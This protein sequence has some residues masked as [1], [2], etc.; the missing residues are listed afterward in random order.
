VLDDARKLVVLALA[1]ELVGDPMAL[2]AYA[3]LFGEDDD[4]TLVMYAPDAGEPFV[5]AR[6]MHALEQAGVPA[7]SGPDMLVLA[8]PG[9]ADAERALAERV[10]AVYT[11]RPLAGPLGA[12]PRYAMGDVAALRAL[13]GP[14]PAR[15]TGDGPVV[16]VVMCVWQRIGFLPATIAQLERQVGVR[17][18]LHLWVN[19]PEAA[20]HARRIAAAAAIPVQVTLSPQNI[21]G[22]GRFHAARELAG[23]HPYVVFIDDDQV[24]ADDA[25]R[26]LLDEA[27]PG[28]IAAQYAFQLECPHSY[29]QRR[30]PQPGDWVQYA[31]TGGMVADTAVF[32]DPR[33]FDC[34]EEFSFV[35]DLWLSYFA[36]HELGWTLVRSAARFAQVDDGCNQWSAMPTDHKSAFV[37]HLVERGW[38]VPARAVSPDARPWPPP[39][40]AACGCELARAAAAALAA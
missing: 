31:G 29:W 17:P 26:T 32:R 6:L 12:L 10:D 1:D 24:F 40:A 2:A 25:L 14:Q 20:D 18:E 27:R 9:S 33:L 34:P 16:P 36:D 11:A 35:E 21:G 4:A 39:A 19:N 5:V 30:I 37:R 3:S 23:R 8:I 13:A 7:D 38:Q 22:I 28:R 15:P